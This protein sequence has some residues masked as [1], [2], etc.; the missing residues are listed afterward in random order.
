MVHG[1]VIASVVLS[2]FHRAMGCHRL[3]LTSDSI[4]PLTLLQQPGEVL[5]LVT[6]HRNS[7]LAL[8]HLGDGHHITKNQASY[9]SY[10]TSDPQPYSLFFQETSDYVRQ[11]ILTTSPHD[12][13]QVMLYIY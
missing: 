6:I 10:V 5:V 4:G 2:S 3:Q 7:N 8:V 9:P 12:P 13:S 1:L 11:W